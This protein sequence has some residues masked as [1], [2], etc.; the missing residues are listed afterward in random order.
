MRYWYSDMQV[1]IK[2]GNELSNPIPVQVGTRQGG[3]SSPFLFNL[4]Y[5]DLIDKL[6]T[7][8]CGVSIGGHNYNVHLLL[9]G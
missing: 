4:F 3:L 6:N 1:R 9:C 7:E 8:N 2:W 5:E